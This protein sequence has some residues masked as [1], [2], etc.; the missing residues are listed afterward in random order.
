[1]STSPYHSLSIDDVR[2][3]IPRLLSLQ[4]TGAQGAEKD[5]KFCH[6]HGRSR[7]KMTQIIERFGD[8]RPPILIRDRRTA[9]TVSAIHCRQ[10]RK[11]MCATGA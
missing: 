10:S 5:R 6:S 7:G 4:M 1:V 3:D 11:M 8:E 9:I 2:T